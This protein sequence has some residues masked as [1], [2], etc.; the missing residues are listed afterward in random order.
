MAV[1]MGFPPFGVLGTDAFGGDWGVRRSR[2]RL[3]RSLNVKPA[4]ARGVVAVEHNRADGGLG[5]LV[6]SL[7][8]LLFAG[9]PKSRRAVPTSTRRV[10]VR[11]AAPPWNRVDSAPNPRVY[12]KTFSQPIQPME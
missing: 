8:M 12:G 5:A 4:A 1:M 10:S 7:A 9:A 2:F 11:F 6:Q 3:F